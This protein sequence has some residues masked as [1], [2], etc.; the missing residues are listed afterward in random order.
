M[1]SKHQSAELINDDA[2]P[3][4]NDDVII[5][6]PVQTLRLLMRASH[7]IHLYLYLNG[8]NGEAI[9][10]ARLAKMMNRKKLKIMKLYEKRIDN[11][12]CIGLT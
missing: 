12:V 6:W 1:L 2:Y 8:S 10:Q 11:I 3:G 7:L 9:K 5:D 4:S